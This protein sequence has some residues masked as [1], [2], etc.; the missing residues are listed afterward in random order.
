[1]RNAIRA[2]AVSLSLVFVGSTA[3]GAGFALYEFSARGNAMG[4][5][6]MANK[7]EAASLAVNPALITQIEG[8]QVQAGATF[9]IP[10]ATATIG[11]AGDTTRS[12]ESRVFT[13]PNVYATYQASENVFLGLAGFSR[14][15]LG[16]SYPDYK[17]WNGAGIAYKFDLV[18]FSVTPVIAAKVTDDLSLSMGL[19]FM[20]VNFEESKWIAAT[21]GTN[22]DV[23]GDGT[24]WGGNFGAY[25]KP[26]WAPKWGFGV[27]YRTKMRHIV[28]G[29]LK[30][31]G[32][33]IAGVTPPSDDVRGS[34]T[35]P[36]AFNF[37]VSYAPVEEL[38]LEAGMIATFWSS[39]DAIR[40]EYKNLPVPTIAEKK[41]YKDAY[42]FNLGAEYALNN[43]WDIRGGYAFDMTPTNSDYMDTLVPVGDRHLF[44]AGFGYK[45][46]NWGIDMAYT[47]LLGMRMSGTYNGAGGTPVKY[48]DG[49]THMIGLTFK[50]SFGQ[51]FLRSK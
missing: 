13:L 4:G 44:N 29:T 25:Y 36:D 7:A 41:N 11:A 31:T 48:T 12:L 21:D 50:Y 34:V 1:M 23:G 26:E 16:G 45:R 28:D 18:T 49:D 39:F 9:V 42:R 46:D 30:T 33:Q 15:G 14:F 32:V 47:Y 17:T 22:V 20:Y 51:H 38:V 3:M 37:G 10:N 8:S 19:E 2:V 43:N 6:V 27:A 5:A 24:G 35:L 40:I